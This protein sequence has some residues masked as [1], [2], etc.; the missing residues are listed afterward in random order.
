MR[1]RSREEAQTNA[2]TFVAN[3]AQGDR[4]GNHSAN[5][6]FVRSLDERD[7]GPVIE[8]EATE[9]GSA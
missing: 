5:D 8:G 9:E 4:T 7:A 6:T 3:A 2:E 1:K